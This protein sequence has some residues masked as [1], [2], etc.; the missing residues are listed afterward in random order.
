[1]NFLLDLGFTFLTIGFI[2][3][4]IKPIAKK[5]V[6]RKILKYSPIALKYLDAQLPQF[7]GERTGPELEQIVSAKLEE[8]TGEPWN[9]AELDHVFKIFDIRIAADQLSVNPK[10]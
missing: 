2:E 7:L 1:M 9:K 3:A 6:Q 10:T 5:F 4:V 8:L